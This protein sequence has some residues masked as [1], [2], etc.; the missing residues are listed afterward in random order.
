[1]ISWGCVPTL[2]MG[3][4]DLIQKSPCIVMLS[5]VSCKVEVARVSVRKYP[6]AELPDWLLKRLSGEMHKSFSPHI[7][8]LW[9]ALQK[10][11]VH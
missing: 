5:S 3:T 11:T 7:K 8:N 1:M 6:W 10:V 2:R 9:A 4:T